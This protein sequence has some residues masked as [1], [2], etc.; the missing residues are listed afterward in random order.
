[1]K[2]LVLGLGNSILTDDAVGFAVVEEVRKRL[3]SGD[4]T[5]SEASA[6]GLSLLELVVGY[7]RVIIV[8]AIQTGAGQP[9]EIHHLSPDQ[10]HGS[11]RGA[12]THAVDLAT[13]LELGRRLGMDIPKEVEILAVETLD[14]ETFSEELTPAVAAVVP[15]AVNLVL[16]R[17]ARGIDHAP[18]R[19]EN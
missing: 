18:A 8:D 4:V 15:T 16:E 9:G 17:L 11:L 10:F 5:V 6:G 2:T 14:V 13:A 3:D 7:D 1:M 12:S 19:A